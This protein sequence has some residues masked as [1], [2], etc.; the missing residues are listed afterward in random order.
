SPD[1]PE[2]IFRLASASSLVGN[3]DDAMAGLARLAGMKVLENLDRPDF[4][5]VKDL[6]AFRSVRERMNGLRARVGESQTAFHLAEKDLITEGLTRDPSSGDFFVGSVHKRKI[7][8]VTKRGQ[9][10]D[11]TAEKQDGL[12]AVLGIQVDAARRL[13]WAC[14]TAVPEMKE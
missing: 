14:S 10:T 9:A 3:K 8:R 6:P 12:W 2:L 13:L 4:D 11:F 5:A 1:N 7:V